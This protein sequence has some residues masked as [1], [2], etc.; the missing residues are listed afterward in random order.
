MQ[1]LVLQEVHTLTNQLVELEK[2]KSEA[3]VKLKDVLDLEHKSTE[4]EERVQ[5]LTKV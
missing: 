3:E 5:Q 4:L 2:F 1:I